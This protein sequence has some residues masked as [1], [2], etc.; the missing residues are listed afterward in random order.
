MAP[1]V[2]R[3]RDVVRG[4]PLLGLVSTVSAKELFLYGP[5]GGRADALAGALQGAGYMVLT[6]PTNVGE[7]WL[8]QAHAHY[9]CTD[10]LGVVHEHV[11]QLADEYGCEFDGWGEYLGPMVR[12]RVRVSQG[13]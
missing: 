6:S 3:T 9:S 2:E 10:D 8:V 1:L 13:V 5:T 4:G 7:T 12:R 11:T